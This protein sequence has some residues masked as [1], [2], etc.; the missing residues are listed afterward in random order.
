MNSSIAGAQ[1]ILHVGVENKTQSLDK[2]IDCG[3]LLRSIK[4]EVEA[5]LQNV[6]LED[7]LIK[8]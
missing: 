6:L 3:Q 5:S 1:N 8:E 7:Q 4:K 2:L